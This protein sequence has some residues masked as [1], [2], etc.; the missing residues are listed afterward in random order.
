MKYLVAQLGARR[1]YA[2]PRILDGAGKLQQLCTD[3]C[4]VKGWPRLLS[5]LP[6][7]WLPE[8]VKRVRS[9]VPLGVSGS[10]INAF[11]SFGWEY[12]KRR[13]EV[14]TAEEDASVHLWAARRFCELILEG[15]LA[16]AEGVYAFNGVG[17]ELLKTAL[18]LGLRT[19]V[20]QISAPI[21][22]EQ[23]IMAEEQEINSGWEKS[24]RTTGQL[25]ATSA[26]AARE[27]AEWETAAIIICA[28]EFTRECVRSVGGPWE[29]CVVVPYG[30]E[31]IGGK[32]R[33]REARRLRVLYVGGV[34]L[35][36]GV[37]YLL[38][39]S[40]FLSRECFEIRAVG[41]VSLTEKGRYA[42][43]RR[44]DLVGAVPKSEM[45]T[46]WE[47]ADVLVFPTLCDGFGLVQ[48]EAMSAGLPVVTTPNSGSVVR[49]G[50]EGF[51]VPIRD[52]EAIADRLERLATRP[53][54]LEAMSEAA[55]RRAEE[56]TVA[57]YGER[58]LRALD[59]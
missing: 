25:S 34:K 59:G 12:A 8:S 40:R 17:L 44:V 19:V 24:L 22:V 54:L 3:L 48:I 35:Q 18:A 30:I 37:A 1:G 46:H 29:R 11:T 5:A 47:W 58:L 14:L 23:R 38:E 31:G 21:E 36:K 45:R 57:K 51:I 56:F 6:D 32:I 2:V 42:M 4:A 26:S 15:G 55:L 7:L 39:A 49:D 20:D 10:K 16:G 33:R 53:G 28:S 43:A 41:G 9:R 50:L 13:R 27:R 52:G